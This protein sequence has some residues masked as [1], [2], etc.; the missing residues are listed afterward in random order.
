[1]IKH[2]PGPWIELDGCLIGGDGKRVIFSSHL[3]AIG[4]V[5]GYPE[6]R[7]N[8]KLALSAPD[9][10]AA[11]QKLV[12]FN[13]GDRAQPGSPVDKALKAARAAIEKATK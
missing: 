2:T 9:L 12:D 7:D 5:T 11:L 8:A 10:L 3:I 1:M 4:S 6:A 13:H